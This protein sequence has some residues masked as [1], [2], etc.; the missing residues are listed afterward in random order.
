MKY[1]DMYS[2]GIFILELSKQS[3][4][5][6]SVREFAESKKFFIEKRGIYYYLI[7]SIKHQ[8]SN[9]D[10]DLFLK[11]MTQLIEHLMKLKDKRRHLKMDAPKPGTERQYHFEGFYDRGD[12]VPYEDTQYLIKQF[13]CDIRMTRLYLNPKHTKMYD[14]MIGE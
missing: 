3:D 8:D 4:K 11:F 10:A 6:E 2:V 5:F 12:Q 14:C 7:N 1:K 9:A 13:G